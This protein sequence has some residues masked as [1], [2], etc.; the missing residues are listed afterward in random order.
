VIELFWQIAVL[1][2]AGMMMLPMTI[3]A[4]LHRC[5]VTHLHIRMEIAGIHKSWTR[6]GLPG[7]GTLR[8]SKVSGILTFILRADKARG[9]LLRRLHLKRLDSLI[10]FRTEDAARSALLCG[11]LQGVLSCIP[12]IRRQP[13]RIQ[14]LPE[15]FR[16]HSTVD[17]RCIIRLRLGT[18]ILTAGLLALEWLRAQRLNESEAT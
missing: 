2:L 18:I 10:L 12:A 5:G 13:A 1:A 16:A 4:D 8:E 14:V 11:T 3:R 7:P 15:F 6:T 9:F 17:V